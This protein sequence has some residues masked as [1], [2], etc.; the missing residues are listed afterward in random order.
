[1]LVVAIPDTV[2]VRK[3]V[4][5]SRKLNP[6]IQVVLR[7]HNEEEAELLREESMGTVFLGEHELAR[8]MTVHILKTMDSAQSPRS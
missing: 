1:M 7:T 4:E 8:G 5:I 6:E 3:M 2:N